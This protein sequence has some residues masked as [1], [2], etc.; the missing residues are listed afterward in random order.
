MLDGVVR[1]VVRLV[2]HL[3]LILVRYEKG[4]LIYTH[5]H[6]ITSHKLGRCVVQT[7]M[8]L[9]HM[10][11]SPHNRQRTGS[12]GLT[13][14]KMSRVTADIFWM[15]DRLVDDL[16]CC[17]FS[18]FRAADERGWIDLES[19]PCRIKLS[20]QFPWPRIGCGNPEA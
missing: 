19:I 20:N 2:G 8:T 6:V 3:M 12:G 11:K 4:K 14:Q 10:R 15:E 18:S 9:W 5:C 13:V 7:A 16:K 1:A 17:R